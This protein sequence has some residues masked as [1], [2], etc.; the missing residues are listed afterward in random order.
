MTEI[1]LNPFHEAEIKPQN[2]ERKRKENCHIQGTYK[3][4]LT[5]FI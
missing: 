3:K 4:K 2:R 1:A 5:S